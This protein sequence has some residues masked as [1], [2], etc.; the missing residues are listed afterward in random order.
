MGRLEAG[1]RA[2]DSWR[3]MVGGGA[4]K[5]RCEAVASSLEPL[6]SNLKRLFR[7]ELH[8]PEL[9]AVV[10][11]PLDGLLESL[12]QP[13]ARLEPEEFFGAGDVEAAARLAVWFG[14]VP[15]D[16]AGEADFFGDEFC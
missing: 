15:L 3:L 6:S 12:A 10:V 8:F 11:E 5:W 13:M 9:V 1:G 7:S 4:S 2:Q 16:R 14:G